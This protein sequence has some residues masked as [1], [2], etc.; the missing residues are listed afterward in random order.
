MKGFLKF[1]GTVAVSVGITIALLSSGQMRIR[2]SSIEL[3][4]GATVTNGKSSVSIS[5][6]GIHIEDPADGTT[7]LTARGVDMINSPATGRT[8]D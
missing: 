3:G 5:D 7:I 6:I 8:S 2:V 4:P 1:V